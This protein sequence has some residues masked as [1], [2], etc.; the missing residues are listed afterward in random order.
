[1]FRTLYDVLNRLKRQEGV[2]KGKDILYGRFNQPS[3][4][5]V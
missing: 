1:M 3:L 5:G 2:V 4:P